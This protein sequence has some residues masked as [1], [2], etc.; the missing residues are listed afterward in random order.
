MSFLYLLEHGEQMAA[1][2]A[3]EQAVHLSD[4]GVRGVLALRRAQRMVIVRDPFSRTLSA[5]LDKFRSPNYQRR[6]GAFELTPEGFSAFLSF[7]ENG[8]LRANAHWSPQSDRIM[9]PLDQYDAV[10]PFSSFPHSFVRAVE[11]SFPEARRKWSDFS[12]VDIEGPPRTDAGEKVM[13]FYNQDNMAA[14][15]R[16]YSKDLELPPIREEA[17]RVRATYEQLPGGK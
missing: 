1:I 3:K 16:L 6:F 5:F 9:L 4:I 14:V 2:D 8:G 15:E 17:D 13:A 11:D 12:H 10:L 7:L